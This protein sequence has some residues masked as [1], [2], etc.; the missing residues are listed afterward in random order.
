[1]TI[2]TVFVLPIPHSVRLPVTTQ[3][4]PSC[5]VRARSSG[6]VDTIRVVDGQ[7]VR[8]GETLLTI[9]NDELSHQVRVLESEL[10]ENEIRLHQATRGHD[11]GKSQVIRQ[12]TVTIETRLS[13]LRSRETG[14]TIRAPHDGMVLARNLAQTVGTYV[15]E[16]EVLLSVAGADHKEWV[17]LVNQDQIRA[18]QPYIGKQVVVT[19]PDCQKFS[20]R[21]ERIDPRATNRLF[22]ATLAAT[23]GGPLAVVTRSDQPGED[24]EDD[25]LR[26]LKPHF[27]GQISLPADA[28]GIL[29][30]TRLWAS[31]GY[32]SQSMAQWLWREVSQFWDTTHA[33]R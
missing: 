14:L 26:L 30:G 8:A 7:H 1:M 28:N 27:Q 16:G 25:G 21:L 4:N 23:E 3:L 19:A 13:Q 6:F 11:E 10:A 22:E 17:T 12:H 24:H 32:Q 33:S 20:G 31:C 29:V 18:V 15:A 5:L 9:V 2:A